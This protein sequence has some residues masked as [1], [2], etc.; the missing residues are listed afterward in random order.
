MDIIYNRMTVKWP[1]L[2]L[3]VLLA[4][5][6][7]FADASAGQAAAQSPPDAKDADRLL[8][9]A[10]ELHQA[11]DLLG[12]IESYKAVLSIAPDRADA[13]SNLGAAYAKLG[14]FDDAVKQYDAALKADPDST[15]IRLN[16]A[17]AYYKSARP[18]QA[19]P[20]LKRVLSSDPAA[21]PAYLVLADCYVQTG[22]Y[23]EAVSLLQPREPMFTTDLAYAFLLGTALL[24]VGKA[25]E[26]QKYVDRVFGAGESAE[27]HLL[28]GMAYLGQQNYREAKTELETAVRLNPE[29]LTA[30]A[31]YGRSLL[32]VGEQSAAEREFQRELALNIND[33]EAN[34]QLG[35]IRKGAQKF[36]EASA[37]LER[38]TAIRPKDVTARKLLAA[39]RLQ[40]GR[41]EEAAAMLE[42]VVKDAPDL[43]EAHV[44]LATAYNRLKR[45]E[46]AAR[47][48]AIVDR[49]NAE[50]AA[51]QKGRGGVDSQR[52]NSQL[53]INAQAKNP[54]P[55]RS[56]SCLG[57]SSS[58]AGCF[59]CCGVGR[60]L[61]VAELRSRGV[62]RV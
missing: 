7:P 28:M 15:Q 6:S 52:H 41:V 4:S 27:G 19:I 36:D 51:K 2:A 40:Q 32:G 48:K 13:L 34:L 56:S 33:F 8:V 11:G 61:V 55:G 23:P 44:Q 30:H 38:A 5:A 14:Q 35:N 22:Q 12:A 49:L 53:P 50:A 54:K 42:D 31:M 46:D 10:M 45:P 47:E 60:S 20:Q 3:A 24:N 29:L 16:L 21:K 18:G 43:V 26:G 59:E 17:L 58:C 37:Y 9:R 25:D 62:D 57:S 39:L 1:V